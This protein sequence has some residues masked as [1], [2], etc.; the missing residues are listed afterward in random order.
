MLN[1]LLLVIVKTY[2]TLLCVINITVLI[3]MCYSTITKRYLQKLHALDINKSAITDFNFRFFNKDI[4]RLKTINLVRVI[5][6]NNRV[7]IKTKTE[8]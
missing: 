3:V 8:S 1:Y 6:A 2:T 5:A 7:S 4:K